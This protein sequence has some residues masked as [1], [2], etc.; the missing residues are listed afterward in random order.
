MDV[1][2]IEISGQKLA[3]VPLA[4]FERLTSEN[5]DRH[6]ERAADAAEHR[7]HRGE[8]Y[9]PL[10]FVDRLLAGESALA[11]WCN[12]RGITLIDLA[13]RAG[14]ALATVQDMEQGRIDGS[15][16]V[17]RNLAGILGVAVD[18]IFPVVLADESP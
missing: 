9:L 10:E 12:H 2:I 13:E 15:P 3:V 8:E 1:Q 14:I 7:R 16:A 6:D 4:D 11:T 5:E 18:D 17:W